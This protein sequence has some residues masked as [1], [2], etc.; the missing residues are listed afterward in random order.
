MHNLLN[1]LQVTEWYTLKWPLLWCVNYIPFKKKEGKKLELS[2][3]PPT[4]SPHV[5]TALRSWPPQAPREAPSHTSTQ[6][7][8]VVLS[9]AGGR[10]LWGLGWGWGCVLPVLPP[11]HF[12]ASGHELHPFICR[13][14]IS[15]LG[16]SPLA[17]QPRVALRGGRHGLWDQRE[18][19]QILALP[20]LCCD[21][22][23]VIWTSMCLFSY[24]SNGYANST[25]PRG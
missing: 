12:Q 18:A 19:F 14:R 8:E 24:L 5:I 21:F 13:T 7:P 3:L 6:L 23:Q 22:R 25:P 10:L 15:K 11:S 17:S 16:L 4:L 2:C 9:G 1:V 20:L